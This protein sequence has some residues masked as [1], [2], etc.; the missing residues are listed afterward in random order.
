L[1]FLDYVQRWTKE[2]PPEY[3]FE[4]SQRGIA[5]AHPR[6]GGAVRLHP[7]VENAL[8]VS[9]VQPNM[10]RFN[11]LESGVPN[12]SGKNN[13]RR[14][15][16]GLV[17]PDYAVRI[18]VLD[19]EEFPSDEEQRLAL[20][21]FR[22]KKA[23]PFS[24]DEAQVSCS[25]QSADPEQKRYEVLAAAIFRPVLD[26]YEGLLR[27]RGFQIGLVL[28]SSIAT[29]PLC[30]C[31]G[32]ELS[33]LAKL[34]GEILSILLLEGQRIRLARCVDLRSEENSDDD[35]ESVITTL[36]H[37]TLAYAEDELGESVRHLLLCGFN[38]NGEAI[39]SSIQN[40]LGL[41][42]EPLLSRLGTPSQENAGLLGLME[43]YAA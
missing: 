11:I 8:D 29:L 26:E 2:P 42:W 20:V 28:P 17:V 5:W 35:H 12:V 1:S 39:G 3:F 31:A 30:S 27:S 40:E 14:V 6:N 41:S 9:P 15:K 25:I 18:S 22:L 7:F 32:L 13:Q 16:A 21:R 38:R 43:Q 34:S 23:V 4:V 33:L 10:L 19:F 24:I 37:Q 36:L